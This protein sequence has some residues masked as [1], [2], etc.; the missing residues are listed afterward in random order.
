MDYCVRE[1]TLNTCE[2]AVCEREMVT[3]EI[4]REIR[5]ELAET[6]IVLCGIRLSLEGTEAPERKTEE[7]KCLHDE[8]KTIEH[9]AVDCM[10]LAHVIADRLFGTFH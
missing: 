7:P 5:K 9:M 4:V 2:E 1:S 8:V 10:G 6:I 3:S